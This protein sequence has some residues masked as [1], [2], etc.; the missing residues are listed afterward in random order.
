LNQEPTLSN[1]PNYDELVNFAKEISDTAKQIA[2]LE[3]LID[4]QKHFLQLAEKT[5]SV[6]DRKLYLEA[7]TYLEGLN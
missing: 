7:I 2:R 1:N 4:L 3:L 5:K 6:R